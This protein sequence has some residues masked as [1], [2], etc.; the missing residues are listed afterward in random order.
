MMAF[1]EA[2]ESG[3]K[4]GTRVET[5]ISRDCPHYTDLNVTIKKAKRGVEKNNQPFSLLYINA[6][7]LQNVLYII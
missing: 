6:T 7:F 2:E 3:V 1:F 5:H 4:K